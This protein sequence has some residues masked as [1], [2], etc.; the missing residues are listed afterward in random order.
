MRA[1][2][3][4]IFLIAM[5]FWVGSILFF[6]FVLTPT[7]KAKLGADQLY[8]TVIVLLPVFFQLGMAIGVIAFFVA[9][10]R[11]LRTDRP[12]RMMKWITGLIIVMLV[13]NVVGYYVL[14]PKIQEL[15]TDVT[16]DTFI[17]YYNYTQ[18][19]SLLNML[20]GLQVLLLVAIDMR[21]LP[22]RPSRGGYT[23]RF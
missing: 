17:Q 1:F 9:I 2:A 20:L 3:N 18:G 23:M 16:N 4:W 11:T 8:N 14:L 12:K 22:G 7:L 10:V 13:L 15:S 6:S 5:S 19:V 21:I